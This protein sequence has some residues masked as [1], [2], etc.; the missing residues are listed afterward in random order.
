MRERDNWIPLYLGLIIFM[1]YRYKKY[2]LTFIL[3]AIITA[4]VS[5]IVSSRMI[6]PGVERLR[7]CRQESMEV[8][9]RARCGSGFSF[10]SSHAANHFAV[11]TFFVLTLGRV[12]R[13]SRPL[14]LSWAFL[15]S[16]GQVYVGVHFPFDILMGSILGVGV[17]FLGYHLYRNL[18]PVPELSGIGRA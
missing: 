7:P 16:L 4:G 15:I 18:Y 8:T 2:A 13:W 5:D 1:I 14:W 11:A 10:T 17:G 6:K 3:C 12:W 9:L